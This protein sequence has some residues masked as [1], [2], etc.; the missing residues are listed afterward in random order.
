M[1]ART[2]F[3]PRALWASL[4]AVAL[5]AGACA[6][7]KTGASEAPG[8]NE[9]GEEAQT[10]PVEVAVL[11]IGS[12]EASLRFS[13]DLDAE[14][15]VPVHSA[16]PASRRLVQLLVEEGHRVS[17]G[18]LLARLEDEEP[19]NAL[20][21]VASQ[22]DKAQVDHERQR[23][24]FEQQLVS[25]QVYTEGRH[26]LEQLLIAVED[27]RRQL[28]YSEVRSP[29]AG[30]VAQRLVKLGDQV[31]H[32]QKL[33]EVVDFDSL[34]VRVY[35]PERELARVRVGQPARLTRPSRLDET[36]PARVE[37]IAPVVDP[38]S[39]TVRVTLEVPYR[40]GLLPGMFLDVAL[41]TDV[42]EEALRVPKRALVL[43]RDQAYVYRVLEEGTVERVV[44]NPVL[45]DSDW[46]EVG[47]GLSVGDRVVV[48]GQAG[49]KPGIAVRVVGERS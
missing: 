45:E 42:R 21:K 7:G 39:G 37:R 3:G 27:A 36:F 38:K 1:S 14:Q 28:S 34:V 23:R 33:F 43:D 41:V 49:L 22:L 2:H 19:R 20:A 17:R 16:N 26:Q 29:I 6:G 30:T 32:N 9:E 24:L 12:M 48:A 44:V 13:A 8:N 25:E 40:P 47:E 11:G 46:V 31:S 35:V 10:P 4:L 5:A 15:A 18:Q